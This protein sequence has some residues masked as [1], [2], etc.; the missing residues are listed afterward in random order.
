[1]LHR[2]TWKHFTVR[3]QMSS[4]SFNNRIAYKFGQVGRVFANCPGDRDLIPGRA[5]PKSQKMV[6]DTSLFNTLHYKVQIKGKVEQ[7][8][9]KS[10]VLLYTSV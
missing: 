3:K 6:L 9:E 7:S 8:R 10:S 1:M 2:N 4:N 5:I